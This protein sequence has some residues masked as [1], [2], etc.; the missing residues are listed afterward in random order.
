MNRRVDST[1]YVSRPDT[2]P[3][4]EV[5]EEINYSEMS[6]P[7]VRARM[8]M[9]ATASG[10]RPSAPRMQPVSAPSRGSFNT[11]TGPYGLTAIAGLSAAALSNTN[12]QPPQANTRTTSAN[13]RSTF[14]TGAHGDSGYQPVAFHCNVTSQ[15]QQPA[16]AVDA[17]QAT[18]ATSGDAQVYDPVTSNRDSRTSST[19]SSNRDEAYEPYEFPDPNI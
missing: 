13:T 14:S 11:D 12:N 6:T 3:E 18:A 17:E 9:G 19:V 5:Y 8:T 10:G 1:G 15:A 16:V 7:P 2:R 4:N